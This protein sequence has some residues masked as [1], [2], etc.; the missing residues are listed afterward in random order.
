MSRQMRKVCS[1][2]YKKEI[3]TPFQQFWL[4]KL[5]GFSYEIHYKS[6]KEIVASDALSRVQGADLLSIDVS[7]V[8]S[9]LML[10]LKQSYQW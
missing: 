3:L 9:D 8:S 1:D 10:K 5:K 6:G 7:L 4:S 2:C